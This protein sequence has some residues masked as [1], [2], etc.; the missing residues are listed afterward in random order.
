MNKD[1][2]DTYMRRGQAKALAEGSHAWCVLA[3]AAVSG[4]FAFLSKCQALPSIA[5]YD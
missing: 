3:A 5:A 2:S 1:S 4:Y